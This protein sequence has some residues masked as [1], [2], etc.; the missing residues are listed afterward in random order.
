M[1][2]MKEASWNK[3]NMGSGGAL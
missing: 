2:I 3:Q 1:L